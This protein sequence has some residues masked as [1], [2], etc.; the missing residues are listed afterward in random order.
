L[1]VHRILDFDW[2]F[3][4]VDPGRPQA[5]AQQEVHHMKPSLLKLWHDESGAT[6]IECG[7]IAAAIALAGVYWGFVDRTDPV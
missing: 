6:A 1:Y 7:L 3:L 2:Q 5:G 4:L